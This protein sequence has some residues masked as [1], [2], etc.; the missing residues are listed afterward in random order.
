LFSSPSLLSA[1]SLEGAP[2]TTDVE[3]LRE[4]EKAIFNA[5]SITGVFKKRC[6]ER[7][8][9]GTYGG[10]SLWVLGPWRVLEGECERDLDL[11]RERLRDDLDLLLDLKEV[12]RGTLIRKIDRNI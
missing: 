1:G 10:E 7:T 11:E 8:G 3:L 9:K 12:G 2:A 6:T 4:G 5:V